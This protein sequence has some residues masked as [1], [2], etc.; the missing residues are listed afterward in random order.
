M[1]IASI[2]S[3]DS[4]ASTSC[5]SIDASRSGTR[6]RCARIP[7]RPA[8]EVSLS[9]QVRPAPPRSWMPATSFASYISRQASINSFSVKGSPTCTLGRR[10]GPVPSPRS[11]KDA[12]AS[13][14]T[15]PMPSRPVFAPSSTTMLPTPRAALSWM[16]STGITPRH[17]AFTSGLPW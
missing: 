13:T 7:E 3:C 2:R 15:P 9:A 5:G 8:A 14:L 6:S 1:T 16:R 12:L 4:L 17:S 10:A 11:V